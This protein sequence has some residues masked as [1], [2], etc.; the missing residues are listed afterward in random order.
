MR[1]SR[2]SETQIGAILKEADSYW[3]V[4]GR[5]KPA[6]RALA[7]GTHNPLVPGSSPGG[8]TNIFNHLGNSCR[9]TKGCES[10]GVGRRDWDAGVPFLKDCHNLWLGNSLLHVRLS[11]ENGLSRLKV[12]R[13]AAS[14]S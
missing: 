4:K 6:T 13:I 11:L 3:T 2:C 14:R 1:R 12:A 9:W 7:S 8:P 5:W 10:L